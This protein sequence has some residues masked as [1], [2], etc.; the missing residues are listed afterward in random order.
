MDITQRDS[1]IW[2]QKSKKQLWIR[3]KSNTPAHALIFKLK[4]PLQRILFTSFECAVRSFNP[5][6]D[7]PSID[8]SSNLVKEWFSFQL[9]SLASFNIWNTRQGSR[10]WFFPNWSVRQN[11]TKMNYL[12]GSCWGY[13]WM[14]L[15]LERELT[16]L[17]VNTKMESIPVKVVQNKPSNY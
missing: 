8:L 4:F 17:N 3:C 1:D 16:I 5:F 7:L 12:L 14:C 10:R 9:Q 13:D 11:I 15:F 6:S 2:S